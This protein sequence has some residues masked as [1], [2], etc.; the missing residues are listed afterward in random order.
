MKEVG[1]VKT[2]MPDETRVALLPKDIPDKISYPNKLFFERDYAKHLGVEDSEYENVGANIVSRDEAYSKEVL[3]IPK[4]WINDVKHFKPGQTIIGW[5]YLAEKKTIARSI[6][7]NKMTAIAWENMYDSNKN[8]TFKKNRW[9]AGYIAVTQGLPFAKASPKNLKIGILGDGRVA[10]GAIAR[11]D[12]EGAKYKVF[13]I[14][15]LNAATPSRK[16]FDF[17]LKKFKDQLKE[18]DVVINCWYYDPAIG[19]YL[20]LKDLQEMKTGALFIDVSSEGVEGS[21][22]HPAISPFYHLGRFNPIII[23]NNNHVPSFWPLEVSESISQDFAP[24]IEKIMKS[25]V[26]EVLRTATVVLSGEIIDKR[27]IRLLVD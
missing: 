14:N 18:F 12:E 8:Y 22:P 25:K 6:L 16:E 9:Y 5:L 3:C 11:L 27:I 4:P 17:I 20:M 26:D 15:L 23:Y 24:Y 7:N 21:I 13:G 2:S 10:K 1:F 19:N